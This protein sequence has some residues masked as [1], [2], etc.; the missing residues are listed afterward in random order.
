MYINQEQLFTSSATFFDEEN[1]TIFFVYVN[2]S[3]N[4][5]VFVREG[6]TYKEYTQYTIYALYTKSAITSNSL[7]WTDK[8]IDRGIKVSEL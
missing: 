7:L 8:H 3:K 1:L 5:F 6:T 2:E 4:D